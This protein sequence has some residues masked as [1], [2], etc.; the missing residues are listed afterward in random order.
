MYFIIREGKY[1]DCS[2]K[3]FLDFLKGNLDMFPDEKP[4]IEDWENHLS[5]IFTEVRLKK[6]IEVYK[7]KIIVR[8]NSYSKT[9]NNFK[10]I[11]PICVGKASVD[12]GKTALS[13]LKNFEHKISEGVIVVNR[14]NFKK[15][16][17]S[18]FI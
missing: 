1:L 11:L 12:M 6:F 8:S 4:T 18:N 15:V 10:N 2:G 17:S 7:T 3:S 16:F 13:L 5:T 14:E 9:Y